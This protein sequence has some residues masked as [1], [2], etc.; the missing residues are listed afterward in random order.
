MDLYS[1]W[2]EIRQSDWLDSKTMTGLREELLRVRAVRQRLSQQEITLQSAVDIV[3]EC[4]TSKFLL[5]SD[6]HKSIVDVRDSL[7][8]FTQRLLNL[9]QKPASYY[10]LVEIIRDRD[11]LAALVEGQTLVR[12]LIGVS[13]PEDHCI[14]NYAANLTS[15]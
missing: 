12:Y 1:L 14:T 10:N 7:L 8:R 6:M 5:N 9:F 15:G 3:K 13:A 11:D 4:E 2:E